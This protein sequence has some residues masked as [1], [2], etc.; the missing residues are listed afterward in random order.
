MGL[1]GLIMAGIGIDL[2][3]AKE[4]KRNEIRLF[5]GPELTALDTEYMKALE[6]NDTVRQEQI[7]ARKVAL[8][9]AP[10]SLLITNAQTLQELDSLTIETI[11]GGPAL[12]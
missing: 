1:G 5:R 11:T 4:V 7:A 3:K 10:D 6:A 12:V 8:R 9:D 2:N